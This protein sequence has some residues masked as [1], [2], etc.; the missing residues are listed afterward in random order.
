MRTVLDRFGRIDVVVN[1]AACR[2]FGPLLECDSQAK[3][4]ALF[5]LNT[6]APIYLSLE[7]ARQFW[8]YHVD[9]NIRSNRNIVNV[10]ST[11]GIYIYPDRWADLVRVVEVCVKYGEL[12]F[13]K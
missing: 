3:I 7:C 1:A 8:R 13:G 6:V 5:R 11:A 2:N 9:D 4:E 10:S 12:S